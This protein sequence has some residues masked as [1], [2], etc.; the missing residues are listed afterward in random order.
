MDYI[1]KV[2]QISSGYTSVFTFEN[3]EEAFKKIIECKEWNLNNPKDKCSAYLRFG[4]K[5]LK[6]V[7][8]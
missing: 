4:A 7:S 3:P 5:V 6:R 2:K 8:P 1:V